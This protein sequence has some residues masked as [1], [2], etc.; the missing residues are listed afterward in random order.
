AHHRGR[1][2]PRA[3]P[4][5]QRLA[6]AVMLADVSGFTKLAERLAQR[7]PDGAE[8]LTG[9]LNAYFGPLIELIHAAGGD[10][11]K[12]AGD[13]LVVLFP[14]GDPGGGTVGDEHLAAATLRAAACGLRLQ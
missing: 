3:V 11:V 4:S 14:V 12:F 8:A 7:G 9:H 10:V 6:A 5:E 13:A 2:A 1:T